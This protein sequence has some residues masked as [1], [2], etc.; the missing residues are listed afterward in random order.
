MK[1]ILMTAV[2]VVPAAL[3]VTGVGVTASSARS[4]AFRAARTVRPSRVTANSALAVRRTPLGRTLVDARGRTLYLFEADRPNLSN[5]SSACLSV[6]PALTTQ[7]RPRARGGAAA[8]KVGT[9]PLR[10]GKRQVTYAGHPLYYYVGDRKPGDT[11]GQG[12]NQFG[13]K[14][15]VLSPAGRKIDND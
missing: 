7:H 5:C 6:W 10:G 1:R 3:A 15:Y 4:N 11:N 9:I 8:S 12:L 2:T 13:A 14:W